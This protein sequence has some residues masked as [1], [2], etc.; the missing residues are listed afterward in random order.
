M[1][2]RPLVLYVGD[3]GPGGARSLSES[4]EEELAA[5]RRAHHCLPG[6][7]PGHVALGSVETC[8]MK[9]ELSPAV[10]SPMCFHGQT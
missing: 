4:N 6:S 8:F 3:P 7:G 1:V 10:M 5:S 2:C 9:N